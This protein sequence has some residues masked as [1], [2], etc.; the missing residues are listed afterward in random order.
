V[1]GIDVSMES[2]G[3][4]AKFLGRS[5]SVHL[6]AMDAAQMGF[7]S[8]SFD[9]TFCTQNGI[10]AFDVDLVCFLPTI[11]HLEAAAGSRPSEKETSGTAA[12][13]QY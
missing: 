4:A 12:P 3:M 2:L 1:V 8:Q 11:V 10:S 7:Q 13:R 6:A 9:L 5:G